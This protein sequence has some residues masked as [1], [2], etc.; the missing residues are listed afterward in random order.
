MLEISRVPSLVRVDEH[1][2]ERSG[3]GREGL[4]AVRSRTEDDVYLVDETRGGEV[5]GCHFCAMG[6]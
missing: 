1:Q 2:V 4:E 5:L 3:G 6:V